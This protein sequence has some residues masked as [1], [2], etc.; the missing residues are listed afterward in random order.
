[1]RAWWEPLR[2]LGLAGKVVV[3]DEI[4]SYYAYTGKLLDALLRPLPAIGSPVIILSATLG[5]ARRDSLL[6]A[7][8]CAQ[9]A[10]RFVMFFKTAN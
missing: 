7:N 3:L 9:A 10:F 5:G 6:G 1:M 4:H 2:L 8:G